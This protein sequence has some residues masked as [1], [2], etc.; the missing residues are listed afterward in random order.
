VATP[1][2][3][4]GA[5]CC[6]LAVAGGALGAHALAGRLDPHARELWEMAARYLMYSG[7][8]QMAAGLTRSARAGA[9]FAGGCLLAGGALFSV[10]IGGLALGGPRWLGAVTP[11]GGLLLIAGF[12]LLAWEAVRQ[13]S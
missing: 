8:G 6:A 4:S 9:G 12:A 7:F 1:W 3:I 10:T 11:L 5:L 13:R 2:I